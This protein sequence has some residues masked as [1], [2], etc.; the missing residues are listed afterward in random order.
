MT[1]LTRILSL[2]LASAGAAHAGGPTVVATDSPPAVVTPAAVHDW[3]GFYGGLGYGSATGG[4]SFTPGPSYDFTSG[5]TLSIFAGYLMQ[6]GAFVYGGELALSQGSDVY[7]DIQPPYTLEEL[8]R[9][10][11][12]KAKAGYAA[13]RVLFYGVLGYSQVEW[14][15]D[16]P[17]FENFTTD[18]FA[19]GLGIDYAA[20]NRLTVGLE[21]LSRSTSGSSYNA[22]QDADIDLDTLSLRIGYQF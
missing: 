22:G 20:T 3:S 14:T 19:Y 15:I 10:I 4:L 12:L 11:D 21:Y 6:R 2:F 9:V 17:A 16:N 13:N 5:T 1:L 18:G 8:G 7:I